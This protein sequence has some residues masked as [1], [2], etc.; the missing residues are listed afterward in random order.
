MKKFFIFI[1]LGLVCQSAFADS[2]TDR[3]NY[4]ISWYDKSKKSFVINTPAELAGVAYLVNNGYTTFK[5]V[6]LFLGKDILLTGHEW[7]AIGIDLNTCFQGTF[8]GNNHGI[9][10]VE[11]SKNSFKEKKYL[12]FFAYL[13]RASVKN[14]YIQYNDFILENILSNDMYIGKI[15]GYAKD[16]EVSNVSANG[17]L[18]IKTGKISPTI[19]YNWCVGG[20]IGKIENSK[21][22][23]C[24]NCRS[25]FIYIEFGA[26]YDKDYY[27]RAS[28][29][30]GGIVGDS[31]NG[32]N[33]VNS[34]YHCDNQ[35]SI[36][37]QT[38]CSYNGTPGIYI[39]GINGGFSDKTKIEC[40]YN[41]AYSF[42]CKN[43]GNKVINACIGGITSF[44]FNSP[45]SEGYIHN[46]YSS[47]V[48]ITYGVWLHTQA[49]LNY[50]G[51][52]AM[53]TTGT[54]NL[55]ASTFS[56]SDVTVTPYNV[57]D[58]AIPLRNGYNGDN[59]FTSEEMKG[60][61]FLD[62]LNEYSIINEGKIIWENKNIGEGFPSLIKDDA[63]GIENIMVEKEALPNYKI[64]NKEL[65][66]D[67]KDKVTVYT[68]GGNVV[69]NSSSYRGE[70]IKLGK[71][72]M[73]IVRCN[74]YCFKILIK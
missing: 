59:S 50:G 30:I 61:E 65:A 24:K 8:D 7:N 69:Y 32:V 12:G 45:Y 48:E 15:T 6:T 4:S 28:I 64:G 22:F 52:S 68:V 33:N 37:V 5:D 16:S 73:Y 49:K 63:S 3:G 21:V 67:A 41:N 25:G 46:C 53:Y 72:G 70:P 39:G 40:C 23:N 11:M 57:G 38:G 19:W 58:D 14:F 9:Y 18:Q 56:P 62:I 17:W 27:K 1:L 54:N 31:D 2:W 34:I 26:L 20:L 51:I 42:K 10:D 71:S 47:T 35:A 44:D 29:M 36:E 74:K 60:Q 13:N 66:I 43:T 55:Y